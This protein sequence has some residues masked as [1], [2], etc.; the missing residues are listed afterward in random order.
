[1]RRIPIDLP[2][3]LL[4]PPF[5]FW[6][7]SDPDCNSLGDGLR[8]ANFEGRSFRNIGAEMWTELGHVVRKDG[9]LVAGA[10]DRDIAEAGVK[11]VWV[12]AG[13]GVDQNSL[14]GEAL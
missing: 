4:Q 10:G 6:H 7:P 5:C 11:Q 12:D 13:V 1:M 2:Q 3:Q 14:G 8:W 9:R